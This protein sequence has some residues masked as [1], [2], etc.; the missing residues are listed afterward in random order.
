MIPKAKLLSINE[1]ALNLKKCYNEGVKIIESE[2]SKGVFSGIIAELKARL[3]EGGEHLVIVPDR[4]SMSVEKTILERL[5]LSA[6]FNIE[7]VTFTRLAEKVLK[8]KIKRCLTP[9]GSVMMLQR[10]IDQ[11]SDKLV[12]YRKS[13]KK[14]GFTHEFYAA[15][16]SLRNSGITP[17]QL[18]ASLE[19]LPYAVRGKFQDTAFLYQTYLE[20]LGKNYTDS[21]TRLE[22]LAFE[23][24]KISI[25]P[26]HIYLTDF[27]DYK[28]PELKIIEQLNRCAL[29]LSIGVVVGTSNE[30]ARIYPNNTFQKLKKVA[31]NFGKLEEVRAPFTLS[32]PLQAIS[33]WLYSYEPPKKI[34]A[35]GEVG[36]SQSPFIAD[37]VENI[38]L[39]I[40]RAV[41]DDGMR[42]RD[43]GI[44]VPDVG[45]YAPFIK[46]VFKRFNIPF[47]IDKQEM[48]VEQAKARFLISALNVVATR[49]SADAVLEFVKNPLFELE[50]YEFENY[51]IAFGIDHTR[52]LSPFTLKYTANS[53][54][55]ERRKEENRENA[56]TVRLKLCEMLEGIT[57]GE[58]FTAVE[59]VS[60][61]KSLENKCENAWRLYCEKLSAQSSFYGKLLEQVDKKLNSVFDEV[62]E[63]FGGISFSISDFYNMFKTA[64]STLKIAL[65]PLYIDSVF[66]GN[67][68]DSRYNDVE[69]LFVAGAVEGKMPVL[70]SGG[71]L[72]TDRDEQALEKQE[73]IV[74]PS[75]RNK[76]LLS[77]FEIVELLKK[78]KRKL[79]VSYPNTGGDGTSQRPSSLIIQLSDLFTEDE[80]K[81]IPIKCENTSDVEFKL[82]YDKNNPSRA[83]DMAYRLCS[84][85]N[86]FLGVLDKAVATA[87]DVMYMQPY[88]AA[89]EFF[90][91]EQKAL[92]DSLYKEVDLVFTGVFAKDNRAAHTSVSQLENYYQCPYRHYFQYGLELKVREESKLLNN[93]Q[94]TIIHAVL[95]LFFKLGT[96]P[97]EKI[98]N[99][100]E[101]IFDEV[102]SSD[103]F[104]TL[105][106][107]SDSKGV[108]RRLR[109]ECVKFCTELSEQFERSLFSPFLLEAK[110]SEKWTENE[111]KTNLSDAVLKPL[112]LDVDG[113]KVSLVG[114]IDRVDKWED[115]IT[116]IDYKSFKNPKLD[117]KSIY[118]GVKIQLYLYLLAL[119]GNFKVKPAGVFYLPIFSTYIKDESKNRYEFKGQVLKDDA[120][121]GALDST[122]FENPSSSYIPAK[123]SK[124][125][126][127]GTDCVDDKAFEM[128]SQTAKAV[129]E[130]GVRE[131]NLGYIA[132]RPLEGACDYC[133]YSNICGY[134]NE[135]ARKL[136]SVSLA[137][138]SKDE[139]AQNNED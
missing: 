31:S 135:N 124:E 32:A 3:K 77:M 1:I 71:T 111:N 14:Q 4:L 121:L 43:F 39:Q 58:I 40:K 101:R 52:F 21:S 119:K 41:E 90:S 29:S 76:N 118:Y 78:P 63:I 33:N 42:F 139:K 66:V 67:L 62:C 127:S 103:R 87:L 110:F 100:V 70:S 79:C 81:N 120:V 134:K 11:N 12:Y 99:Q 84:K 93:E 137:D 104:R 35:E 18:T 64:L 68:S 46:S 126:A 60:K 89:Y 108:I 73:I 54:D 117:F 109:D 122:F 128:L 10:V 80:A 16:T 130:E 28:A 83:K 85:E 97:K 136:S 129:A 59:Y 25:L 125:K 123:I 22:A 114:K 65:L 48:L 86:C 56:E 96:V 138:L 7:I 8:G 24:E 23:L 94:G 116:V 34:W 50:A 88:D 75:T 30:N 15:L 38:A 92:I 13:A 37:E 69:I 45:E 106:E 36:L 57:D 113:Q 47:F 107:S 2:N 19:K 53:K 26:K 6:S 20:E 98:K 51:V 91:A 105:A 72:I 44:A 95:E 82:L 5:S 27:Y 133:S 9:E 115:F 102:I 74:S 49:F 61:L 112:V 132:P 55:D 131:I 17:Q